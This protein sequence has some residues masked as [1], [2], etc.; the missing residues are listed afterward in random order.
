MVPCSLE[1]FESGPVFVI[2]ATTRPQGTLTDAADAHWSFFCLV[3]SLHPLL[4]PN[5]FFINQNPLAIPVEM[6]S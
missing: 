3:H 5:N 6:T 1:L 4:T 2:V